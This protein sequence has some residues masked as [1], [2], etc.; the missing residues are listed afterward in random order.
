MVE[1]KNIGPFL[2][3][4]E[5]WFKKHQAVLL[6]LLNTP[7]IKIWFRWAMRIRKHDCPLG[8]KIKEIAPN[9]YT[10]DAGMRF[11]K[12]SA[13]L[14]TMS[15]DKRRNRAQRRH[16]EIM[17]K[18][19]E[20]GIEPDREYLLP[21][22]TTDFRTHNKY[23]KRV[24]YALKPFWWM[25][26]YWDEIFADKYVPE[27]SF[28]FDTLT[29]YPDA[30]PETT[31]VDGYIKRDVASE[32]WATIHDSTGNE[33]DDTSTVLTVIRITGDSASNMWEAIARS[34]FL[35]NTA[36]IDDAATISAAVLSLYG[37]GKTDGLSATPNIDIYTS[38][39]A[40]NTA[41]ANGDY[42]QIGTTS[43]TGTPVTY[44]GW[45]T[46]AY[47][48]FT[49]NGTGIGNVSKTSVSKF[50]ARNANYDVAN[51]PPT[52]SSAASFM[53]CYFAD[54]SGTTNDPKLVVTY[55][56]S[57]DV[58][59]AS[60]I[61]AATFSLPAGA[62]TLGVGIAPA[63][64][65]I[66]ASLPAMTVL[67]G[68]GINPTALAATFSL[69]IPDILTP[70]ALAQPNAVSAEFSVPDPSINLDMVVLGSIL[71][72]VFST[73][74]VAVEGIAVISPG[75]LALTF[76]QPQE[77]VNLDM[78][79][80]ATL[81]EITASLGEV[82]VIP[83]TRVIAG[84]QT[85]TFSIPA[86]AVVTDSVQSPSPVELYLSINSP[87]IKRTSYGRKYSVQGD[88]YSVKYI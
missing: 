58:T 28:G 31:T 20:R 51:T 40:S 45:S 83:E 60:S 70:D 9:R 80:A 6:W 47:N 3:F 1:N 17:L 32:S 33:V 76:S 22:V 39:P 61:L 64:Q 42:L 19:V 34:I 63:V 21:A 30:H 53:Q 57:I 72:A 46:S 81:Q 49:F 56:T 59:V 73:P 87:F 54:E 75:V 18:R 69:P 38:T 74:S 67:L 71:S 13:L 66:V 52:W 44:S 5:D 23:G 7:V 85:L 50:G 15:Q 35:F 12:R 88:E 55:S 2:A 86:I 48:A 43:Q 8:T 25:L 62:V 82:T 77:Q 16:A 10:I 14:K 11:F 36:S 24:Y 84:L 29:A 26:H 68:I 65:S 41:L 27:Y 78:V 37:F 79:I 4:T